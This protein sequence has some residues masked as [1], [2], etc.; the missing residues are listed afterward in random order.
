MNLNSIY[1]FL[2]ILNAG[3]FAFLSIRNI[4][5][6]GFALLFCIGILNDIVLPYFKMEES[7]Y[8]I[9][10]NLYMYV[11]FLYT[12][13]FYKKSIDNR[14]LDSYLIVG[15][16]LFLVAILCLIN[17]DDYSSD[18][19]N[20]IVYQAICLFILISTCLFYYSLLLQTKVTQL[21]TFYPF[22]I[23]T[24]LSAWSMFFVYRM[25]LLYLFYSKDVDFLNTIN[26]CFTFVNIV[27]YL[28][29]F[30]AG[31]CLIWKK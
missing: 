2:L 11:L 18:R 25:G 21:V 9:V 17:E 15:F 30:K 22:W 31:L 12:F 19:Y 5:C 10:T 29:F 8:I 14:S 23:S 1:N 24:G 26:M 20:M 4:Y 28:L 16:I 7:Y 6:R 13:Y 3:F 27:T